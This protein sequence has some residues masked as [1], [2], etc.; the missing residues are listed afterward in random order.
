MNAFQ[1]IN[2]LQE[3][4]T[5]LSGVAICPL[6]SAVLHFYGVRVCLYNARDTGLIPGLKTKMPHA[7]EQLSSNQRV[8][9]TKD[10]T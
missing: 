3:C 4:S 10:P 1:Y 2:K 8:H 5:W 7:A 9:A 6:A